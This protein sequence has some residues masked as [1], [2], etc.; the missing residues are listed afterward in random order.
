MSKTQQKTD[1]NIA[2]SE[3]LS[4]EKWQEVIS[5]IRHHS[6]E[7]NTIESTITDLKVNQEVAVLELRPDG[8]NNTFRCELDAS[9][10]P[11][12]KSMFEEFVENLGYKISEPDLFDNIIGEQ[13]RSKIYRRD[14]EIQIEIDTEYIEDR[15]QDDNSKRNKVIG[16]LLGYLIGAIPLLNIMIVQSANFEIVNNQKPKT[17]LLE[18]TQFLVGV[19]TSITIIYAMILPTVLY[20]H[21]I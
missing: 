18:N 2:K 4:D 8:F 1:N 12:Q 17:E 15:R 9:I 6:K 21:L 14:N 7:D 10:Q 11:T 19:M 3:E 5:N 13:C 16:L 20:S